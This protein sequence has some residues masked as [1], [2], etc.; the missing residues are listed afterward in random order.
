MTDRETDADTTPLNV[1]LVDDEETSRQALALALDSLGHKPSMASTAG[2]A[3]LLTESGAH[4]LALVDLRLGA[5]SGLE[6]VSKLLEDSPW[7]KVAVITAHGSI[8]TAVEAMRRGAMDYLEKPVSTAKLGALARQISTLRDL[9][10][11]IERLREDLEGAVPPPRF[12]TQSR[13]MREVY[14][15][16]RR[17][18]ESDATVLIRGESGTGKGVLARSIHDWSRRSQHPFAVVSTPA[19]GRELLE[20]EL[21]GHVKGAFTGAVRS[22]RGRI[23]RT[24]GGTLFLDEIGAMPVELQPKLLRFLQDRTFERVGGDTTLSADVRV[25]VATNRDLEK[26]VEANEFREDLYFRVRVVEIRMPPLRERPEDIIPLAETF[27]DFFGARYGRPGARLTDKA[28]RALE[29][30]EWPGN[31][32]ELQNAVERAVILSNGTQV[33]AG[34]LPPVGNGLG[35]VVGETPMIT[36][37]EAEKRHLQGVLEATTSGKDAAK[38]LGISTTTLW[39]RRRKHDL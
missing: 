4:D 16:A 37:D 24:E 18:A 3:L 11:G 33:G 9:E 28:K 8:E 27:V 6:L 20:S 10:R 36:L 38:V 23:S 17:V 15:M 21:F 26:A 39:R 30:R 13:A 2:E 29:E 7:L 35:G 14:A 31:V 25:L 32:R 12:L 22:R 19:L 34:S 1:L 5:D